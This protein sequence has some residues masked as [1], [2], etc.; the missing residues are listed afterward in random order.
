LG[1]TYLW[2][3]GSQLLSSPNEIYS[4][5]LIEGEPIET[6]IDLKFH[7]LRYLFKKALNVLIVNRGIRRLVLDIVQSLC[8]FNRHILEQVKRRYFNL[9]FH[10]LL[11][12][13][14]GRFEVLPR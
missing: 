11:K 3:F 12:A 14:F 1:S 7:I 2:G 9:I 10:H 8:E 5:T 4:L 6:V 13:N